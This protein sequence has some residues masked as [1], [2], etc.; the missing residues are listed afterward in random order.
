MD[1]ISPGSFLSCHNSS[2]FQLNSCPVVEF[3]R[4]RLE[5]AEKNC[6]RRENF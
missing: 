6:G 5:R 2:P 1:A 3:L 4:L